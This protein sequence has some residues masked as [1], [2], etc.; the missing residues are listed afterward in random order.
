MMSFGEIIL[1]AVI[2]GLAGVVNGGIMYN[3]AAITGATTATA[4]FGQWLL[5]WGRY[6]IMGIFAYLGAEIVVSIQ[7][8]HFD[9]GLR[10]IGICARR[11]CEP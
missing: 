4:T 8:H 11:P 9:V 7:S 5:N 1:D 2:Y 3:T 6:A 10:K